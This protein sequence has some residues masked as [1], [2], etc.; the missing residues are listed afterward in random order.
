MQTHHKNKMR[1]LIKFINRLKTKSIL[2]QMSQWIN[3]IQQA[4]FYKGWQISKIPKT[5]RFM[6]NK[7][8]GFLER[9]HLTNYWHEDIFSTC[10]T[11]HIIEVQC[12]IHL[13]LNWAL[14][15]TDTFRSLWNN[16]GFLISFNAWRREKHKPTHT[17]VVLPVFVDVG[18]C[19]VS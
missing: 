2:M 7:Q 17:E 16:N 1:I 19:N 12:V 18:S 5:F 3:F 8:C 14:W 4:V 6:N 13:Q 15:A 9:C 10:R 11:H